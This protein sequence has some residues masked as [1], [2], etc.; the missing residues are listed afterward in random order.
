MNIF[1]KLAIKHG[2]RYTMDYKTNKVVKI[3]ISKCSNPFKFMK[4]LKLIQD[5]I[6]R[7]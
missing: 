2:C 5:L 3:D 4:E 6:E 7:Y 1:K